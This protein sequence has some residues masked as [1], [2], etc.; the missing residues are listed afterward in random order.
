[1]YRHRIVHAILVALAMLPATAA[2]AIVLPPQFVA[3]DVAP[4]ANFFLPTTVNFLPDGRLLVCEKDG[5]MWVVK[6]GV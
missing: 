1:M 3:Q 6:N 4:G 5:L 2:F